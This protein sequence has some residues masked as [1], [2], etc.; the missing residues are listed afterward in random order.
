MLAFS[1]SVNTVLES[2]PSTSAETKDKNPSNQ[3]ER[4]KLSLFVDDMVLYIE[5]FKYPIKNF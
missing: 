5:N 3:K 4:N 2:S 1:T